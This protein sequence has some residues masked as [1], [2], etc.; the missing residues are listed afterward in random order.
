MLETDASPPPSLRDA[1]R[2][3]AVISS[4]V[5][6][7]AFAVG[8]TPVLLGVLLSRQGLSDLA[9]GASAACSPLGIIAASFVIPWAAERFGAVR[10]A[11]LSCVLGLLAVAAMAAT[12]E[13]WVWMAA[14]LLWGLAVGG[15]YIVNKAWLAQI[16]PPGLRGR[17]FGVYA[18]FLSA[19][20]ACGPLLV[21]LLDFRPG[22]CFALL[23]AAFTVCAVG[24]A[25]FRRG[26]PDFRGQRRAPVLGAI[27]L[28]PIVLVAAAAYGVFDHVTLAFLPKFG[29]G[30]G[31]SAIAMGI[32]LSV[33]N[34]GN[35]LL[36]TPIGWASD[37]FGRRPV[38]AGCALLTAVGALALPW[39]I[40][41]VL[42]Y[43]F[44]FV[45]GALAYGVVTVALAAIGD[46]F[47]GATLL[48]CSAAMT[49]AGGLGGVLGPPA[50]GVLQA[51]FGHGALVYALALTFGGLTLLALAFK[52]VRAGRHG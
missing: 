45:W 23:G 2:T 41:H 22:P 26:L 44:L 32:G 28:V 5:G 27:G 8:G 24:V 38:L 47:K 10:V 50:V 20:F 36:Q 9:I 48:S 33:L 35:V 17:V 12:P 46:H 7:F 1:W 37:R 11:L 4:M 15:F 18:S 40:G 6:V 25:G 39:A 14:R 21:A 16:T 34:V 13:Q 29:L 30:H 3:I 52:L 49:M 51:A 19:G 42:L 43:P 31:Q